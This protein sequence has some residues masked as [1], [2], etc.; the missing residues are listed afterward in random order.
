MSDAAAQEKFDEILVELD[1]KLKPLADAME[2]SERL[3]ED[4]FAIMIN[5]RE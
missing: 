2:A 5:A 1:M 4:D 3:S